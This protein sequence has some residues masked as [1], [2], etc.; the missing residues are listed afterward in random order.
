MSGLRVNQSPL[1]SVRYAEVKLV[2]DGSPMLVAP[3]AN[4]RNTRPPA[5]PCALR[6]RRGP[7]AAQ[8]PR[9]DVYLLGCQLFPEAED[10]SSGEPE[11]VLGVIASIRELCAKIIRLNYAYR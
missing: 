2:V 10:E 7:G 9:C 4:P 8:A 6:P 5:A 1:G 3:Q 11:V